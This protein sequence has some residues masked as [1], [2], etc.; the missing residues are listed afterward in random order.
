[1][2]PGLATRCIRVITPWYLPI[3]FLL[4]PKYPTIIFSLQF[5]YRAY[6]ALVNVLKLISPVCRSCMG[7]EMMWKSCTLDPWQMWM[8]T[9]QYAVAMCVSI[10]SATENSQHFPKISTIQNQIH[11]IDETIISTDNTL[12]T[13]S[14]D[15]NS[16]QLFHIDHH[17]CHLT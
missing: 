10:S 3:I 11:W 15:L 13:Q 7:M 1:M 14:N 4:P 6:I 9:S 8:Q 12:G 2:N 16:G 5:K 17:L